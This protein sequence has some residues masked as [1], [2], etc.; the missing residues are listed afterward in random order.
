[1]KFL[2]YNPEKFRSHDRHED[3]VDFSIHRGMKG[4]TFEP[5]CTKDGTVLMVNAYLEVE[6]LDDLKK[7]IDKQY[8]TIRD[9]EDGCYYHITVEFTG[10]G[11]VF[12]DGTITIH[13]DG[14]LGI[15]KKFSDLLVSI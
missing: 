6:S 4:I 14:F 15:G 2:L 5:T 7:F 8:N 13:N 11:A 1:M 9:N 12:G 3:I 10:P